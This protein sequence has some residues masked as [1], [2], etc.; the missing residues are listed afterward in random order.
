MDASANFNIHK[1]VVAKLLVKEKQ[2]QQIFASAIG[3]GHKFEKYLTKV[4]KK[5]IKR[6]KNKQAAGLGKVT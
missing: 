3:E 2:V 6:N 4:F 5:K 1:D